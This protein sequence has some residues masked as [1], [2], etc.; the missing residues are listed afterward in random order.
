MRA[1]S[2]ILFSSDNF[3]LFLFKFKRILCTLLFRNKKYKSPCSFKRKRAFISLWSLA[4]E[5]SLSLSTCT[6]S[7][8][9]ANDAKMRR[10]DA[11]CNTEESP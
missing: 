1:F 3:F 6:R 9:H 2:I 4:S 8:E 10:R 5:K 7:F 11:L